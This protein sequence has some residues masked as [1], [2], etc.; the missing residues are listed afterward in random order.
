MEVRRVD[1]RGDKREVD[2]EG[3]RPGDDIN[4][5]ALL[6]IEDQLDLGSYDKGRHTLQDLHL[7]FEERLLDLA[8]EVQIDEIETNELAIVLL[9]EAEGTILPDGEIQFL[10][11]FLRLTCKYVEVAVRW[12]RT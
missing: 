10:R 2:P 6:S 8:L 5:M 4:K 11:T 12:S 1:G 7:E 9:F 3:V